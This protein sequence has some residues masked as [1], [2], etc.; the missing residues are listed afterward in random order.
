ML[1]Y[2]LKFRNYKGLGVS[3]YMFYKAFVIL[4]VNLNRPSS[5]GLNKFR[6]VSYHA[7]L[8]FLKMSVELF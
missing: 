4:F 8:N 6:K 2:R 5:T 7:R 1:K 3:H